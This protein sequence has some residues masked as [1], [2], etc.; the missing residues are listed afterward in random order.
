MHL[1]PLDSLEAWPRNYRRGDVKAIKVSIQRFGFNG[2]LKV[3]Q[4]VVYAGNH[5]LIALRELQDEG[6]A[7]PRNID[8]DPT[9]SWL[10]P[11]IHID[12]L[13]EE[14]AEAFAIADNHTQE[15][16]SL[17]QERLAELLVE[18]GAQTNLLPATGYGDADIKALMDAINGPSP[19]IEV[20][21]DDKQPSLDTEQGVLTC[22]NCGE[23]FKPC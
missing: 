18:L 10:V 20:A 14:E 5:Q 1:E 19:S 23:E 16:G 13:S 15:L 4:S 6:H 22:P 17:D 7:R 3:R 21:R 2:A 8:A 9:G 11:V 12:H